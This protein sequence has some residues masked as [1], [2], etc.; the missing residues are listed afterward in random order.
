MAIGKSGGDR[1]ARRLGPAAQADALEPELQRLPV[2]A[3][4]DFHRHQRNFQELPQQGDVAEFGAPREMAGAQQQALAVADVDDQRKFLV[5]RPHGEIIGQVHVHEGRDV[6]VLAATLAD[7]AVA[8]APRRQQIAVTL[9]EC[10]VHFPQDRRDLA[11]TPEAEE[12]GQGVEGVAENARHGEQ[13]DRAAVGMEA[14]PAHRF[15]HL[16]AQVAP[17][18]VA[19]VLPV[20]GDEVEAVDGKQPQPRVERS[21]FVE[22][23]QQ[24]PDFIGEPVLARAQA[25]MRDI[26]EVQ[27][28]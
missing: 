2:D 23:E 5:R 24:R 4:D 28:R 11:V 21:Q 17:R 12:N 19:A 26:A 8:V 10:I 13:A 7:K 9:A 22:I 3:G 27:A 1:L 25:A 6:K 18:S 14:C 16:L 15:F 20:E